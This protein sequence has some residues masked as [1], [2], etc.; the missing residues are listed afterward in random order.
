[1][2]G[3]LG[4][5][6]NQKVV[7]DLVSGLTA[8]Q[9][10]GQDAA[11]ITTFE[12]N[13]HTK[14][15]LGLVNNV[16]ES[17]HLKRLKG[18]MGLGHV[19]YTTQGSNELVNAQPFS[20]TYPFGISMVHNGNIINFN[21]LRKSL[22]EDYHILP[23]TSND[24]ELILYTF[25]TELANSKDLKKL[26]VADIF[27][28]VISLQEKVKGAYSSIALIANHGLLAF[29]DPNGIRPLLLGQKTTEKG[30]TYGFS[31]ESTCFDYLGYEL[32]C[33]LEPGQAVFIDTEGKM[34]VKDCRTS[35]RKFCIFEYIYFARE[36]SVLHKK[37]VASERVKMGKMLARKVKTSGLQPDI[38]IDV[39]SSAY[40]FASA[41]AEELQV[42]YRR[43]L[44][45]NNH[46][47][48]S[49]IAPTQEQREKM[50]RH[51]LNPIRDVVAGKKVAVV[52]DSIV[53]GTTSQRI[54]QIIRD[55]GATEVYFISAAPPIKHPCVYGIDMAISTELI[56]AS[57][58]L[59]EIRK[60][61][62]A[63]AVIYQS[64]EDMI[65]LYNGHYCMACFSGKYPI[66]GSKAYL[67]TVE[68]ERLLAK[69][70]AEIF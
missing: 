12:N 22:Y 30:I 29:S 41:M 51:K 25:A 23:Q 19:R 14:K 50:V 21:Q 53:R 13:F 56:A 66:E 9:H 52:D 8:L 10:R 26:K 64:L 35:D 70:E 33:D 61:M 31:S 28:A 1:M 57:K 27:N 48:R 60:F 59:E 11:G 40:F 6:G 44:V 63:D 20:V 38:V 4:F 65:Q 5:A 2:C 36:D 68:Q 46:V 54:V 39:P 42:P 67:N 47:G 18:N 3:I 32:L 37:L 7:Y 17:K 34:H 45:K 43:G 49:F 55:A 69:K 62:N 16:F 24:L 15:G 58:D